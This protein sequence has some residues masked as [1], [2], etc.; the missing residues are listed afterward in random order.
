VEEL[1]NDL[2]DIEDLQR[3]DLDEGKELNLV[4]V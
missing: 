3:L 4:A 2:S 1:D